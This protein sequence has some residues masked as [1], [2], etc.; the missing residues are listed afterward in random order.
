M[1]CPPHYI[2]GR[3][4]TLSD[5]TGGLFWISLLLALIRSWMTQ[6]RHF[7]FFR[8]SILTGIKYQL[9]AYRKPVKRLVIS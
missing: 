2:L 6:E 9:S 8:Y 3:W 1:I 5:I 7:A 4:S